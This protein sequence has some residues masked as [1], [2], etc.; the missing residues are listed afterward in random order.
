MATVSPPKPWERGGAAGASSGLLFST[1]AYVYDLAN[2]DTM[3]I[4]QLFLHQVQFRQEIHYQTHK[5][6]QYHPPLLRR[7]F[8]SGRQ[9]SHQL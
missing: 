1:A 7:R 9:L 2:A 3:T 8:P 6:L 4:A 5:P